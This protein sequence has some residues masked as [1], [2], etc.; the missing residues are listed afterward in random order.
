[1]RTRKRTH[2]HPHTLRLR[3]SR[4]ETPIHKPTRRPPHAHQTIAQTPHRPAHPPT[5]LSSRTLL[6]LPLTRCLSPSSR[7]LLHPPP[8]FTQWTPP[9]QLLLQRPPLIRRCSRPIPRPPVNV[10]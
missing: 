2:P 4:F 10:Y 5:A 6:L 8:P 3:T 9:R 7:R 1:M